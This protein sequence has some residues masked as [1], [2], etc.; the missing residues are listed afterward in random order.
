[1]LGKVWQTAAVLVLG[2]TG[3]IAGQVYEV[4]IDTSSVSGSAGAIYLQFNGGLNP[5]AA[6]VSITSFL[7]GAPGGLRATPAAF[8]DGG[9]T[10]SLDAL[11]LTIDN[12]TGLND[13][14]H[15][16]VY[17]SD[18][19]FQVAFDLPP[20][21]SGSSG[22]T[23]SFGLTSGDGLTPVLTVDAS[24]FSGQ[25]SYD[26][27]GAFTVDTLGNDSIESVV[28]VPSTV[29]EPAPALLLAPALLAFWRFRRR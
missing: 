15:F 7:M 23:F 14:E 22:S 28:A 2:A 18:L 24:G 4:T 20:V 17:G 9:V 13:Y 3:G 1:M 27:K 29:P 10:G 19:M 6:S 5:D 26:T 25:I 16:L 8:S 11:P 12:S 21:L